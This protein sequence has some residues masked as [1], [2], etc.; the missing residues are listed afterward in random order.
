M[1]GFAKGADKLGVYS[2]LTYAPILIVAALCSS[3]LVGN[4]TEKLRKS[5]TAGRIIWSTGFVC[6][7][8]ISMSFMVSNAYSPFLYFRF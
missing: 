3:S 6:L 2:L 1:F 4:L 5:G 8:V 7:F